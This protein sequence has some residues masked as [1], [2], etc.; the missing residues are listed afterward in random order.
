[1]TAIDQQPALDPA[2]LE[3]FVFRAVEE[4]GAALNAA[5]VVMGDRLG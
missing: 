1:M 4:A 3:R 5:L 2:K